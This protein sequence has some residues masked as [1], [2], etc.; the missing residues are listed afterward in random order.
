MKSVNANA[1]C[2][3]PLPPL[4]TRLPSVAARLPPAPL[5]SPLRCGRASPSR[6][7][8]RVAPPPFRCGR[9]H[10]HAVRPVPLRSPLRCGRSHPH[11]VRPVPL[12]LPSVAAASLTEPPCS[13]ATASHP[14][15]VRPVPLRLP[16]V[17]AASL[18]EPLCSAAAGLTLTPCGPR[19]SVAAGLPHRPGLRR[20]RRSPPLR[21]VSDR[22]ALLRCGGASPS[23]RAVRS[24]PPP[25]RSD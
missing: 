25:L 6:R 1:P 24:A 5:C 4:S 23:R 12:R 9:S 19:R 20:P 8:A 17:A 11:A 7:A 15:A 18:T 14:H 2:I 13:A 16:P 22:A 21:P 3:R 10:P